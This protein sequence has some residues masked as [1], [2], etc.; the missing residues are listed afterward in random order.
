MRRTKKTYETHYSKFQMMIQTHQVK[1]E[2]SKSSHDLRVT[3]LNNKIND[4][5]R[6]LILSK[7]HKFI[8]L[9]DSISAFDS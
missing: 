6:N 3:N 5:M 7:I 4:I 9:K 8:Y 2:M 1:Q